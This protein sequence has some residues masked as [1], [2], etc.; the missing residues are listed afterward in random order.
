MFM[1]KLNAISS[2]LS[3]L[4]LVLLAAGCSTSASFDKKGHEKTL[5]RIHLQEPKDS[6]DRSTEIKVFRENPITVN[7]HKEPVMDE[8][9]LANAE[10][11]N[12][13]GGFAIKLTFNRQGR[14]LLENLSTAYRGRQIAIIAI[15]GDTPDKIR[16]LAAPYLNQRITDG[17]LAFT[18]DCTREEA[19]RIVLGLNKVR[20]D[21]Q[22]K[23]LLKDKE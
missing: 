13:I 17:V 21:V 16:W 4:A 10:V 2:L 1:R 14:W 7:I 5:L 9:N 6:T 22:K 23:A 20:E 19:D 18:P 12:D 8:G 11:V 3:A 15:F